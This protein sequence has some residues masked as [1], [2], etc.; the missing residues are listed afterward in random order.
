[1]GKVYV[2][3][4]VDAE[5]PLYESLSATF[6]RI[7]QMTGAEVE[8]SS[9]NL[10]RIQEGTLPLNGQEEVAKL[11]FCKRFLS[12]HNS[13]TDLE[14][15]LERI[16]SKDFRESYKD[17]KGN[18]WR[19]TFF[20]N[21]FV[22]FTDNPRER[23]MGYHRIYDHY[24]EF[25]KI[26]KDALQID[27]IQW[28]THAMSF[29]K[30]AHRNA[31]SLLNSPHVTE[32]LARRIIDRGSFPIC[33]RAGFNAERPDWN[34][35]LEQYIP[36]DFSN[37][38]FSLTALDKAQGVGSGR[39][40]DWRRAP[41]DWRHYHPS[42]DDYQE[43]GNC[44]RTIFRCLNVGTRIRFMRQQDVDEAFARADAGEDTI[45]AFMD[46][47]FRD[48]TIDIDETYEMLQNASHKFPNIEWEHSTAET[49]ARSVCGL[50]GRPLGLHGE[51]D[52]ETRTL[53]I[54]TQEETFGPQ[55]FFCIRT[56][57]GRYVIDNLDFQKPL[58][59]WSYTFDVD[60]IPLEAVDKIGIA[61]NS[62]RG[63]GELVVMDAAGKEL[64]EYRW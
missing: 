28:H 34:W 6:E 19:F 10:E 47:D 53:H 58:H 59:E 32:V 55:P 42:H 45:L 11:A 60:S 64:S 38:A 35:F 36:F 48:L 4:C 30:E 46:H 50:D 31:T 2:V 52:I 57:D 62:R 41:D 39:F 5:G 21:D 20:V 51:L 25:Y 12:Y 63:S 1:M 7:R 49:A 15:M 9:A 43:E 40:G 23:S 18:G 24:T 29:G 33:F 16:T 14:R 54:T 8:P 26:H 3:H 44:R 37:Q 56:K 17:S 27:S 13:W 61:S 22:D